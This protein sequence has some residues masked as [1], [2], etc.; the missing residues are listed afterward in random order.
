VTQRQLGE[1]PPPEE[2]DP[3]QTHVEPEGPP[4]ASPPALSELTGD[5]REPSDTRLRERQRLWWQERTRFEASKS[6]RRGSD[7][8]AK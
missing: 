5:S 7:E 6:A 4:T 3:A 8:D 1:A 2:P